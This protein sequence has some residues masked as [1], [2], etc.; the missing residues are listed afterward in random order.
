ML[1]RRRKAVYTVE[2]AWILS[3]CL[4]II[5]GGILFSFDLFQESVAYVRENGG[6]G[7]CAPKTFREIAAAKGIFDKYILKEEE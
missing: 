7:I 2:A 3:I 4:S 6:K 5:G 1:L